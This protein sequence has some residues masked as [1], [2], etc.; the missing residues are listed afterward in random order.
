[1]HCN[2]YSGRLFHKSITPAEKKY[3][4]IY[5]HTCLS[6]DDDVAAGLVEDRD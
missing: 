4:L 2:T 6:H 1:M 5:V 3:F